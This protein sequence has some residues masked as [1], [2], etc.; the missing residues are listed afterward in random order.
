[1][2]EPKKLP[3][4]ERLAKLRKWENAPSPNP[5]YKG[6]TPADIARALFRK[7]RE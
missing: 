5:R 6:A 2:S 4:K 1:M 3:E 7:K